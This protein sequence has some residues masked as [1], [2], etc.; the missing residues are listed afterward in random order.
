MGGTCST[1]LGKRNEYEVLTG[2]PGKS[3]YFEGL[4]VDGRIMLKSILKK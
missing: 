1:H 4:D 3:D 2:K